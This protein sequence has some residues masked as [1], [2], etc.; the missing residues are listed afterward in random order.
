MPNVEFNYGDFQRQLVKGLSSAQS[1]LLT[2]LLQKHEINKDQL[3]YIMNKRPEAIGFKKGDRVLYKGYSHLRPNQTE[4]IVHEVTQ[5]HLDCL[6]D[7]RI[8]PITGGNTRRVYHRDLIKI[9]QK[10]T[11]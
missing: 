11:N 7:V 5:L 8:K 6:T 9:N 10:K 3:F 1:Q 4:F 2:E